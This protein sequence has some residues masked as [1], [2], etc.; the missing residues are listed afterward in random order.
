MRAGR[1]L[2]HHLYALL[3]LLIAFT[4]LTVG[5]VSLAGTRP[6][7]AASA[8][9]KPATR[10]PSPVPSKTPAAAPTVKVAVPVPAVAPA[11]PAPPLTYN[12]QAPAWPLLPLAGMQGG[13]L[14][15]LDRHQVLWAYN[16]GTPHPTA[17]LGKIFT[18][19]VA[20]DHAGLDQVVTVPS[21][22]EDDNPNHSVMGLHA[23][24][25]V[26][27]RQLIEGIWLASGDDAAETLAQSF[28]P[29]DQFI[30]EMNAK[31]NQLGLSATHL[32]NPSGL[33]APAQYSSP[34]DFAVAAGW[35]EIHYPQ[36][37]ALA[38]QS[39]VPLPPNSQH[40]EDLTLRTLNKMVDDF[41]DTGRPY[42]GITGLKTGYT[43]NAGGCVIITATRGG[44]HLIAVVLGDPWFFSDAATLLDY[45]FSRYY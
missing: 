17:S 32:E 2:D 22:G 40:S 36:A 10:V 4:A 41:D 35:L 7:A 25:R 24:D 13:I 20:M 21:G 1:T 15:D 28:I 16:G 44:R 31:A 43:D 5:V 12:Q 29:R 11:P 30:A 37:F 19:M 34:Y 14:V 42:P 27:V 18:V 8:L 26:T 23:G 6:A 45:G 33:D 38:G 39:F 3:A 9:A